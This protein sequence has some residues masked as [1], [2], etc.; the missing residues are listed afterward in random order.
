MSS[1]CRMGVN[2]AGS[3]SCR[4]FPGPVR[5]H[6]VYRPRSLGYRRSMQVPA[7]SRLDGRELR[8]V[9]SCHP[10]LE[11]IP[12][13]VLSCFAGHGMLGVL[14]TLLLQVS[15]CAALAVWGGVELDHCILS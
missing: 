5:L 14:A 3:P 9:T 6:A 2:N 8:T 12:K 7:L 11:S 13:T 1:A 10:M 15:N 4:E